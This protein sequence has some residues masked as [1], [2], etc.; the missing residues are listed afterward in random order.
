MRSM[1][2]S[3]ILRLLISGFVGLCAIVAAAGD[4]DWRPTGRMNVARVAHTATLLADGRVLVAGGADTHAALDSAELFDPSTGTWR[5]TGR[6][7]TSRVNHTAT[8]LADGRV[9]VTGGI[10]GSAFTNTAELY[11]PVTETW[12]PAAS[13]ISACAWHAATLL[14]D[15]T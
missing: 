15:G 10:S 9:L 1:S 5:T 4:P 3:F 2:K 12:A 11:D 8:L 7:G 13:M 6:L 14:H